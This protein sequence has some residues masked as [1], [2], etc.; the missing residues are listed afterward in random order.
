MSKRYNRNEAFRYEFGKPL[1]CDLLFT[2][3]SDDQRAKK[4]NYSGELINMS[5][6]GLQVYL[7]SNVLEKE[8][9]TTVEIILTLSDAPLNLKGEIVWKRNYLS[10]FSY[11]IHLSEEGVEQTIIEE[12]KRYTKNLKSM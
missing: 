9:I 8:K 11:G 10:G 7:D 6:K 12:L 2:R 1:E 4:G 3:N 5:P